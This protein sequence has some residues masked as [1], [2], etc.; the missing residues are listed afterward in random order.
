MASA[1]AEGIPIAVNHLYNLEQSGEPVLRFIRAKITEHALAYPARPIQDQT[2]T[3][4]APATR[5]CGPDSWRRN[6]SCMMRL[7]RREEQLRHSLAQQTLF[8]LA[9]QEDK[10][11]QIDW[12]DLVDVLQA[13]VVAE[14]L[15]ENYCTIIDT[16]CTPSNPAMSPSDIQASVKVLRLA[17]VFYP[18][19]FEMRAI[20]VYHRANIA[21]QGV[22][23]LNDAAP[24]FDT[25]PFVTLA[26]TSITLESFVKPN[27]PVCIIASS[28]S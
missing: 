26:G 10:V 6:R 22:L 15:S 7:L 21:R 23:Q 13:F 19:D 12:L 9:E 4:C 11:W 20:S 16:A 17:H 27:K 24:D 8:A 14:T 1:L 28:I 3:K 25:M 18:N 5:R 2:C